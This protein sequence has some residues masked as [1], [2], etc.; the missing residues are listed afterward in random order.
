MNGR[1][2][3]RPRG[4]AIKC[5]IEIILMSTSCTS[6]FWRTTAHL[7]TRTGYPIYILSPD[8]S[9]LHAKRSFPYRTLSRFRESALPPSWTTESDIDRSVCAFVISIA[10]NMGIPD[11][12]GR[13]ACFSA[14]VTG[15]YPTDYRLLWCWRSSLF[16]HGLNSASC[17][18]ITLWLTVQHFYVSSLD[19]LSLD[20]TTTTVGQLAFL[21]T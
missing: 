18:C 3:A 1:R 9:Q 6:A 11:L 7:R 12:I 17:Y 20:S 8:Y 15:L 10:M 21:M 5:L 19:S 4:Q 14:Q 16:K 2:P 13:F